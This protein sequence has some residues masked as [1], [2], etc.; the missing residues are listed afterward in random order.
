ME[1]MIPNVPLR[2][3]RIRGGHLLV[4]GLATTAFALAVSCVSP[5]LYRSSTKIELLRDSVNTGLGLLRDPE[6]LK[7]AGVKTSRLILRPVAGTA[8]VEISVLDEEPKRAADLANAMASAFQETRWQL[9]SSSHPE[10]LAALEANMGAVSATFETAKHEYEAVSR[11]LADARKRFGDDPEG[12]WLRQGEVDGAMEYQKLL[13]TQLE[14]LRK[15]PFPDFLQVANRHKLI[16][17]D[18]MMWVSQYFGTITTLQAQQQAGLPATH[19]EVLR[20]R[21]QA[22]ALRVQLEKDAADL[23]ASLALKID[24]LK[25][26][27]ESLEAE[28]TAERAA[29]QEALAA[30]RVADGVYQAALAKLRKARIDLEAEHAAAAAKPAYIAIL[31]PAEPQRRAARPAFWLP[32]LLSPV[33]GLAGGL[34]LQWLRAPRNRRPQPAIA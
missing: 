32:L 9:E 25:Q 22:N 15:S 12:R 19:P 3:R 20:T 23:T 31:R 29:L 21:T 11:S 33:A 7:R 26:R 4:C 28:K 27:I 34:L 13:N 8:Q 10:R 2:P 6:T 5:P 17:S 14:E 1:A 18:R 30:S 16:N 24:A